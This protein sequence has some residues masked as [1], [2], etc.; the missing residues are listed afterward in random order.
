VIEKGEVY[1]E[2]VKFISIIWLLP[3]VF[4]LHDF[5]EIIF[6]EWW[7]KKHKSML[8]E[9]FPRVAK[10][11]GKL[12]TAAFALAVSEEFII[13]MFITLASVIFRWYYLWFG[14]MIGFAAHLVVHLVQ[15]IVFKMYIPAIVTTIPSIMY[16]AYAIYFVINNGNMEISSLVVWGIMGIILLVGNLFLAHKLASRLSRVFKK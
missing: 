14:A 11:Y 1:M 10:L 12:S 15:W 2:N 6:M 16:S 8:L 4:M 5:E 13:L 3:L 9:R 7:V